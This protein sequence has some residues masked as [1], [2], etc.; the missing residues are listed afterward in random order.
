MGEVSE[1]IKVGDCGPVQAREGHCFSVYFFG[2]EKF[3]L[4]SPG[5]FS[6]WCFGVRF[7]VYF[8]IRMTC[9]GPPF[10]G[11]EASGLG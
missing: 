11:H 3:F 5:S 10:A 4:S 2:P 9:V 7:N 8:L 6:W 1:E